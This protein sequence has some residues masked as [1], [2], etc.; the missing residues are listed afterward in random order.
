MTE[1]EFGRWQETNGRLRICIR[2]RQTST[3]AITIADLFRLPASPNRS[4]VSGGS[5][6]GSTFPAQDALSGTNQL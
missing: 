4:A 3:L 6:I 5:H 1:A 2:Q